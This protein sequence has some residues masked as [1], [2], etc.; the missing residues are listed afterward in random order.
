MVVLLRMLLRFVVDKGK[1]IL[2]LLV[3][4]RIIFFTVFTAFGGKVRDRLFSRERAL[5]SIH[6]LTTHGL[7]RTAYLKIMK[8][9][10]KI[11]FLKIVAGHLGCVPTC[12]KSLPEW[13]L[14]L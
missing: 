13:F 12:L 10:E 3:A 5:S 1:N 14:M 4:K 2:L 6:D 11:I 7:V 9:D 8:N